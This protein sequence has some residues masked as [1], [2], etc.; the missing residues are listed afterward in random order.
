ML[1]MLNCDPPKKKIDYSPHYFQEIILD[2]STPSFTASSFQNSKPMR[3]K[4]IYLLNLS[5]LAE[6]LV[7]FCKSLVKK[8]FSDRVCKV[9]LYFYFYLWRR[10]KKKNPLWWRTHYSKEPKTD[11]K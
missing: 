6:P 7:R 4:K 2:W 9:Q 5:P 8:E 1:A 10:L 3:T 11:A